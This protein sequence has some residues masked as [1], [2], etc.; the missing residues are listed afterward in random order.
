MYTGTPPSDSPLHLKIY[1][2]LAESSISSGNQKKPHRRA[3]RWWGLG[4]PGSERGCS[5]LRY[6]KVVVE[7]SCTGR[8]W[9]I[10]QPS[11]VRGVVF[12][13]CV[14]DNQGDAAAVA[15]CGRQGTGCGPPRNAAG[16]DSSGKGALHE[17]LIH[18]YYLLLAPW[19]LNSRRA[20]HVCEHSR[21]PTHSTNQPTF[22][23]WIAATMW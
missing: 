4:L 15:P 10:S 14:A 3:R 18:Q 1:L 19:P 2:Y 20:L 7:R 13:G 21:V 6:T 23:M 11:H 17:F 8:I 9:L 12:K 22:V 16:H 5:A